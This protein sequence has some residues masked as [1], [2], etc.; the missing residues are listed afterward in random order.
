M[1]CYLFRTLAVGV[2]LL[3]SIVSLN[4]PAATDI[5]QTGSNNFWTAGDWSLGHPPS[6][7]DIA[8][9]NQAA[10]YN[11]LFDAAVGDRTAGSIWVNAG[12]VTLR[13]F[14]G[15]TRMLTVGNTNS[16]VDAGGTLRLDNFMLN[17]NGLPL[18]NNGTMYVTG[19]GISNGEYIDVGN[20][21]YGTLVVDGGGSSA[22]ATT[23]VSRWGNDGLANVTFSGGATGTF[24]QINLAGGGNYITNSNVQILS[25]AHLTTGTLYLAANGG[26][27]TTATLNVQGSG[28]S[29]TQSGA[30]TLT[31]GHSSSGSAAINIGTTASGAVFTTGTGLM[32]IDK[33]GTVTL[34]SL[35]D[36]TID[37]TLNA[38][39]NITINGGVLVV[40]D[41]G[42]FNFA[43]GKTMTIQNGGR[44]SF[45][46]YSCQ[47]GNYN[48]TGG[49]SKLE[50]L[51]GLF[52]TNGG[53]VSVSNGGLLS[54]ATYIDIGVDA[55]TTGTLTVDGIGSSVAAV[56]TI[57]S[58]WGE[59]GGT[60]LITFS[61]GATGTFLDV[62]MASSVTRPTAA[63]LNVQTG[64]KVSLRDLALASENTPGASATININGTGSRVSQT[65][66]SNLIVGNGSTSPANI[67]IGTSA[68]GGTLTTGTGFFTIKKTG[69]VTVGGS[70]TT[71][72]LIANTNVVID[73]GLLQVSAGSGVLLA[74]GN[75]MTLSNAGTLKGSGNVF[76]NVVNGG[77]VAPGLSPGTLPINGN[78]IQNSTGVLQ[79][80]L[81]SIASFDRLLVNG[82][83]SLSGT[84]AVSLIDGF[85]PAAG[86]TFDILDWGTRNGTFDTLQLPALAIGLQWNISQL[87]TSGVVSVS[88]G[89]AGDYNLNGKVDAADYVLWRKNPGTYGGSPNGYNTWRASFGQPPGSGA[90]FDSLAVP[91]PTAVVLMILAMAGRCC[92]THRKSQ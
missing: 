81:S 51:Y 61:N 18:D 44:A 60:A 79:I 7:T 80:E 31:V 65:V 32:T 27:A 91:E 33:T 87:Y 34:G 46:A 14:S 19:G 84:L 39:G 3:L 73:G 29:I 15:P 6:A 86:N 57:S 26:S 45:A 53:Q 67:N 24:G 25:G 12:D 13:T 21:G 70:S 23:S 20:L 85:V 10:T 74:S 35:D 62:N 37:G 16:H 50:S 47:N 63:T 4:A 38:N 71:G 28:S 43:A 88:V 89:A 69:T 76:G 90:N 30:S 54:S 2:L 58:Y 75:T 64:A 8:Y 52:I 42:S 59:L 77:V 11:V 49:S 40:N 78:Y 17:L 48:I 36:F 82:A 66:E 9:F 55:A 56:N 22:T 68:S 5:W 1:K 92:I 72:S 83:A 41:V